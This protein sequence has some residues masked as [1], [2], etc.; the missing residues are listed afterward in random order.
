MG[1]IFTNKHGLEHEDLD[2]KEPATDAVSQLTTLLANVKPK[3]NLITDTVDTD[4][5]VMDTDTVTD[6][7]MDMDMA[8]TLERDLLS[9][10][11]DTQ[12]FMPDTHMLFPLDLSPLLLDQ[13]VLLD[14]EP[15]PHIL[16]E[17]HKDYV[18]RDPLN[19]TSVMDS[20]DTAHSA[21]VQESLDI[22]EQLPPMLPEAHKDSA[23]R[24]F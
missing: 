19:H 20:T 24:F 13:L 22:Q 4:M 3:L 16:P 12:P 7:V 14:M 15:E 8:T 1:V 23:N 2:S 18:V 6:T 17:A 9:H 21:M 10:T 5:V 11:T